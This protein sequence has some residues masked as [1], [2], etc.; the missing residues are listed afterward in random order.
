MSKKICRTFL[1][2]GLVWHGGSSLFALPVY[3]TMVS[4]KKGMTVNCT[5]CHQSDSWELT[6]YGKDFSKK[7]RDFKA[8]EALD[9][10][11]SDQDGFTTA[12]EW[13][14]GSN[15]G[16]PASTPKHPGNWLKEVK[17]TF[18]PKKILSPLFPGEIS[19]HVQE[20]PLKDAVIVDIEKALGRKLRDEEKYPTL[21]WVMEKG[22][23]AGVASYATFTSP[24]GDLN[25]ALV[26]MKE[27][28]ILKLHPQH[29][30]KKTFVP[31]LSQ[32]TGKGMND[33][34]QIQPMR[35]F[36]RESKELIDSIKAAL[37]I[38]EKAR[39]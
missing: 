30:H 31:F 16:D 1:I 25:V 26:V 15:P 12:D 8:I 5:L 20:E 17:P 2:I 22:Q 19:Y 11:D 18:P 28:K 29:V 27:S 6:K 35:G 38:M 14:A 24:D 32:F 23:P 13:K 33:L 3:R 9:A 4:A 21:F 36:E 34:G 7:G 39:P 10:M 37:S